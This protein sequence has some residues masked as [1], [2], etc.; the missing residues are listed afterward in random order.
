M[1]TIKR[2]EQ[3]A[4][5]AEKKKERD[6]QIEEEGFRPATLVESPGS[7]GKEFSF[8]PESGVDHKVRISA[9]EDGPYKFFVQFLSKDTEYQKFQCDLQSYRSDLDK[10]RSKSVNAKYIAIIEGQLHRVVLL[11]NDS[12]LPNNNVKVRLMETGTISL[13]SSKNL[14]NIPSK[15][16]H[17]PPFALLCQL[18][19]LHKVDLHAVSREEL[20]F[21][22]KHITNQKQLL[23]RLESRG[24][25][26]FG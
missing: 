11:Q 1:T 24:S 9:Y 25:K 21:Y 16:A 14:Y 26:F 5:I 7:N 13:V 23:L 18:A 3:I 6:R 22:F 19:D 15:V 4:L 17:V 12:E 8:F 20:S 10:A 2:E